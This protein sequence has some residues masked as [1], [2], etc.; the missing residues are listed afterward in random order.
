MRFKKS[1]IVSLLISSFS[2]GGCNL[3]PNNSEW[4]AS[5]IKGTKLLDNLVDEDGFCD[6]AEKGFSLSEY[7][8]VTSQILIKMVLERYASAL[9]S[10]LASQICA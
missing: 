2:L 8:D 3:H 6:K 10:D 4:Y 5:A 1:I 7:P 9:V